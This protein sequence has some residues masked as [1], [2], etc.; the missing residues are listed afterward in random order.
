[1]GFRVDSA[2]HG[3]AIGAGFAVVENIYYLLV[4]TDPNPLL[5]FIRGFGTA[6][7]HSATIAVFAIMAKT[8]ADRRSST[9]LIIF[10]QA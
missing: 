2:I 4:L 10:F 9:H 3:F 7:M 6:M 5:W 1:M 8:N